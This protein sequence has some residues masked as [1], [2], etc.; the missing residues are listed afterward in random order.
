M[1]LTWVT[2]DKALLNTCCLGFSFNF[3]IIFSKVNTSILQFKCFLQILQCISKLF[4]FP[5]QTCKVVKSYS[6]YTRIACLNVQF[7]FLEQLLTHLI[8]ALVQVC[9]SK[10]VADNCDFL[11]DHRQLLP[12]CLVLAVEVMK[13]IIDFECINVSTLYKTFIIRTTTIYKIKIKQIKVSN[14]F[15]LCILFL[16]LTYCLRALASSRPPLKS[17]KS[18]YQIN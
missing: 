4:G 8:I 15:F 2:N 1:N 16:K 13:L 11:R 7:C 9:H 3:K 14:R 10:N 12:T 6:S 18:N 17:I 5:E